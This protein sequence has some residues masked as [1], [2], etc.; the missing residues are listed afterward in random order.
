MRPLNNYILVEKI[1]NEQKTSGGLFIPVQGD[2]NVRVS[3]GT[4]VAVNPTCKDLAV[5][6]KIIY[7]KFAEHP[8]GIDTEE[9]RNKIFVRIEDIEAIY[10]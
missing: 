6:D 10:E 8:V 7:N 4:V 3:R 1:E 2:S 9:Y 5:G